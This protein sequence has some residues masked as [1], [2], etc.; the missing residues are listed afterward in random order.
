MLRADFFCA[1]FLVEPDQGRGIYAEINELAV[2][3]VWAT[4]LAS[5]VHA[6]S[7]WADLITHS[8]GINGEPVGIALEST[9]SPATASRKYAAYSIV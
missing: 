5:P 2:L 6:N 3:I 9:R 8:D 7:L 1:V 4:A